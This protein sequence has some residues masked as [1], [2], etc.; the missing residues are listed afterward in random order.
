MGESTVAR[1]STVGESTVA[2]AGIQSLLNLLF[3]MAEDQAH[4]GQSPIAR[5]LTNT[6][7]GEYEYIHEYRVTNTNTNICRMPA[8]DLKTRA[9]FYL[10]RTGMVP[11]LNRYQPV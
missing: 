9:P 4:R 3:N 11:K 7:G 10:L 6:V 2:S 5:A 8:N 1:E